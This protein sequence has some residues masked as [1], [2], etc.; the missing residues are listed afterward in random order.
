MNF[1]TRLIVACV[2]G[3]ALE[4]AFPQSLLVPAGSVWKYL[5]DG[6]NQGTAWQTTNFNDNAWALGVAE[7]G[8]GD[9]ADGRPEVTQLGYGTNANNK[10]ITYYFR[11][12]FTV[13]DTSSFTNLLLGVLRDDGVVVYINGNEVWRNNMPSGT[14]SHTTTAS[15]NVSG[16]GEAI[17]YQTNISPLKIHPGTNLIAVEIHQNNGASTD[18]SF[19]LFLLGMTGQAVTQLSFYV[20][21]NGNNAWSGTSPSPGGSDGPFATLEQARNAVR[22]FSQN[23]LL[24]AGGAVVEVGGGVY[25]LSRP[26]DL[27]SLDTGQSQS[28]ILYRARPGEE[29]R[30]LAGQRVG[31]FSLVTDPAVLARMDAAARGHVWQADLRAQGITNFGVMQA[32]ST[33]AQSDPGLEFFFQD[34]P[35]TLARWPNKGFVNMVDVL[36]PTPVDVRGT[37]GCVEGIFSYDGD[38]PSRWVGETDVMVHGFWFWDWAD[39]RQKVLSLDATNHIINLAP[40]Y[41]TFGYRKGQWFYAYNLLPELDEPG[42][43]YL[44]RPSGLLYFWPPAP[45]TEGSAMVSLLPGV[46]TLT[47]VSFVTFRGF[48]MEG[49][50]QTAISISGG[51]SNKIEACTVRNVG[52]TGVRISNCPG[53]CVTGSDIYFCGDGGISLSGGDRV[54]LTPAGIYADHNHIHDWSRWNPVYHQ[55]ISLA[56]VGNRAAHNLLHDAPHEAIGFGGNDHLIEYNEIHSVVKES[57][58]AGVM[59]AGRTWTARGHIIRYNYMHHIYGFEGKGCN[60]VYLDDQFSSAAVYGNI[61]YDVPTA[62]LIGG[63]RDNFVQNNIFVNCKTSVSLDARG[64]GWA[65]SGGTGLTNDL[66]SYPYQSPPWSERYPALTN[67]LNENPMAPAGNVIGGNI[68][69]NSGWT[70]IETAALPGVAVTN[71]LLYTD[72]LFADLAHLNF[73]LQAGSPALSMGFAQIPTGQIGPDAGLLH[74]PWPPS[75]SLVQP[76]DGSVYGGPAGVPFQALVSDPTRSSAQVD[77][78]VGNALLQ[79]LNTFPFQ[80]AWLDA[81]A[82]EYLVSA[83]VRSS[84]GVAMTLA[85][86]SIQVNEMLVATGSV[87][88]YLDNGSNQ[89]TAWRATNFNDSTWASGPGELGY[90]DVAD[91]RP[92]ATLLS[93]GTNANNKFITYYFR[94][95]FTVRDPSIYTNLALG[96]LR[97]DGVVVYLNGLEVWRNN[98]TNGT[99]TYTTLALTNVSGN[100]EALFYTTDLAPSLLHAGTNVFAVEIH[101]AAVTST[102]IGFDLYLIGFAGAS[103]SQITARRAGDVLSLWWPL[104][105]S[106]YE[107]QIATSLSAPSWQAASYPS[108]VTNGQVRVVLPGLTG[109]RFFRL[110]RTQP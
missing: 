30:L 50:Q 40:P 60:C 34:Q 7:L 62:I 68:C 2:V 43:W 84:N 33:W 57:N 79:T 93:Y 91:G 96:V 72:P 74:A 1:V 20:A 59:Y 53:A 31:G 9:V 69:W 83:Q 88:K 85:P 87:W 70:S 73:Q 65:F 29:V 103:V 3:L 89:G 28:P 42:E 94:R 67:I 10:Y 18:I 71:N 39:Q 52:K 77:L 27:S 15:T 11:R 80:Y 16:N 66:L 104:S 12:T 25:T 35:M 46:V 5:D 99:I 48:I 61:F 81:S 110:A 54:T 26:L 23:N 17:F 75:V 108:Q 58:D 109:T 64:L 19:D 100:G 106:D 92:E 6:S 47:N 37:V 97:D 78:F 55:G 105:A 56:G 76:A 38:R 14:I 24:P 44:D 90:G 32:G 45:I 107:L 63:G 41:H 4:E 102:D 13:A 21:T 98:I 22:F 49:C 8:Y 51:A 95:A 101:Q 86:L 36:G 82:G